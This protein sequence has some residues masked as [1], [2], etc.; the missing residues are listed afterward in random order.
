MRIDPRKAALALAGVRVANGLILLS[1][2]DLA[3]SLYLGPD[4]RAPTARALARF[5][6]VR[7]LTLG[8]LTGVALARDGGAE[9][10]TAGAVCDAVDC[11]ISIASP[12][13][14][15]KMR[16]AAPTAA[17]SALIGL[18]AARALSRLPP[19]GTIPCDVRLRGE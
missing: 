11:L 5:T 6:G 1:T 7:E 3:A 4:G 15:A 13:V 16:I 10:L 12:A 19:V 9:L 2:P 14:S 18:W 8:V 17:A